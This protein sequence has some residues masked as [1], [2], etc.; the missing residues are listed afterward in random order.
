M[1]TR[2]NKISA[3]L[4]QRATFNSQIVN[5]ISHTIFKNKDKDFE[6]ELAIIC[7]CHSISSGVYSNNFLYHNEYYGIRNRV[8]GEVVMKLHN[9]VKSQMD[10][11]LRRKNI[12]DNEVKPMTMHYVVKAVNRVSTLAD[13]KLLLPDALHQCV[14]SFISTTSGAY[15]K[16]TPEEV[17]QF[18]KENQKGEL[19]LKSQLLQN[20]LQ[21]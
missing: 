9:S 15:V 11:Y 19:A 8:P 4:F 12:L 20:I 7:N 16:I 17:E 2:R 5:E 14:N 6:S 1:A 18:K 3:E 13:L 10:D 21:G